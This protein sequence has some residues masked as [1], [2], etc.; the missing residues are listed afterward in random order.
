MKKIGLQVASEVFWLHN[1]FFLHW[2]LRFDSCSVDPASLVHGDEALK[3]FLDPIHFSHHLSQGAFIVI[4]PGI[5][6]TDL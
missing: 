2:T 4:D 6:V 1:W 5:M 3:I